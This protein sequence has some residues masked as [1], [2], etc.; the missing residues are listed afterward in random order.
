MPPIR[1]LQNV[2]DFATLLDAAGLGFDA[3]TVADAL[4]LAQYV[5]PGAIDEGDEDPEPDPDNT[6]VTITERRIDTTAEASLPV[7]ASPAATPDRPT[8]G[9]DTPQGIPIQI[10]AA[11]AL[12]ARRELAKALRPLMLKVPSRVATVFDAEATTEQIAEQGIWSAVMAPAPERWFDLAIVI[13]Q[14][15]STP[16]WRDTLA[17]LKLLTERQ[18]AFRR[19]STWQVQGQ[20]SRLNLLPHW[21]YT[22]ATQ[23]TGQPKTLVDPAGRR[24]IW[25]V[26]DCTS[27]LWQQPQIY[28]WLATWGKHC[29]TTLVQLLPG[30]LWPRTTLGRGIPVHL[31][32]FTPGVPNA[33]LRVTETLPFSEVAK[34]NPPSA[35][36]PAN[37]QDGNV[38]EREPA[39]L[40]TVP[41]VSLEAY[42]LHQWAR[43]IA[44]FGDATTPGYAVNRAALVPLPPPAN[45][46][47]PLSNRE[48]V[49]RF[50]AVASDM[51][52]QL[53]GLMA[54]AP[55]SPPM[56]QLI[57]QTLLPESQQVHVAEVYMSGLLRSVTPAE[58]K[59]PPHQIQYDFLSDEVRDT[60]TD[61]T[62]I[63]KT[64]AVLDA[65]S[66]YIAQRLGLQVRTYEALLL[67]D[68]ESKLQAL[69]QAGKPTEEA[70]NHFARIAKSALQRLG[71]D[72]AAIAACIDSPDRVKI[73][74][75]SPLPR[76]FPELKTF[77]FEYPLVSFENLALATQEDP[78]PQIN[79]LN[80]ADR[81][82]LDDQ[83]SKRFIELDS[84]G[85]FLIF[86]DVS[87]GLIYAQ[88]FENAINKE[89]LACDPVTG[90]PLSVDESISRS[91]TRTYS[92][93]T[94]KE[95][96]I[97]IFENP[98]NPCPVTLL[99]HAAYLGRELVKAEINLIEE[100]SYSQD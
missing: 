69:E 18:G 70:F 38:S 54:A 28:Q 59:L 32:A 16:I 64:E 36:Q 6:G 61:L 31:A 12:R 11:P 99:D 50:W 60:L 86:L 2:N 39:P 19:V 63:A 8:D 41:V 100:T 3:D 68:L 9:D 33:Q 56:I 43:V 34:S 49:Q 79:I 82:V 14:S 55:V 40:V 77:E 78:L 44:G 83:L 27:P 26:S 57:Q 76:D 22:E 88:H 73:V 45:P 52:K 94:A 90:E 71:G 4:W 62:P 92:G 66:G 30:R 84:G 37:P 46:A 97:N 91:P 75:P 23:A 74:P 5:Q 15:R 29:P 72:Y 58:A 67:L 48:R 7:T 81:R 53:A 85:Y 51:A 89:G 98:E 24:I 17:E 47:P 65:V 93:H 87:Q 10:P 13:E 21:R 80:T 42:P 95:L 1:Q 96:C 25:L 20:G 35:R